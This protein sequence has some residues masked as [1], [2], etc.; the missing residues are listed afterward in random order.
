LITFALLSASSRYTLFIND[1]ATSPMAKYRAVNS[2]SSCV[3]AYIHY[4][5]YASIIIPADRLL[6]DLARRASAQTERAL[7]D[8]VH[9]EIPEEVLQSWDEALLRPRQDGI[10]TLEWLQRPP[11]RK[12]QGLK[13]QLAKVA[14][15]KAWLLLDS[16]VVDVPMAYNLAFDMLSS[17]KL[18]FFKSLKNEWRFSDNAGA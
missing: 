12:L 4:F 7:L 9:R 2:K 10:S 11:R 16:R 17:L 14:F 6:R 1:I 15:L 13:E 5:Y 18:L 8:A 3:K